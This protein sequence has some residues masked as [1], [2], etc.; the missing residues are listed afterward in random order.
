MLL[1]SLPKSYTNFRCAIESRDTL[2]IPEALRLK[3]FEENDSRKNENREN[4]SNSMLVRGKTN[5]RK[6]KQKMEGSRRD[7]EGQS[8]EKKEI[9][10]YKCHRCRKIGHKA[11]DCTEEIR[12]NN[13]ANAVDQL[14]LCATLNVRSVREENSCDFNYQKR[15]SEKSAN[16][17]TLYVRKSINAEMW[18][19]D[20]GCTHMCNNTNFFANN[21]SEGRNKVSLA[22]HASSQ[23]TGTGSICFNVKQDGRNKKVTLDNA[24]CVPDLRLNLLSVGRI[25]D[26]NMT[27]IFK[28]DEARIMDK[29]QNLVLRANRTDNG[30][31]CIQPIPGESSAN[32]ESKTNKVSPSSSIGTCYRLLGHLNYKDLAQAIEEG[33]VEGIKPEKHSKNDACEICIKAKMTRPPFTRKETERKTDVLEIIHTDICGPMRTESLAKSKYFI[34]F[35]DDATRWCEVRFLRQKSEALEAL[36]P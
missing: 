18:C 24:L 21:F 33:A 22:N 6:S 16:P 8:S 30:L 1:Y 3:I 23:V 11:A 10:K 19:V 32:V 25:C 34:I 29:D 12:R 20:S 31:Y 26:K 14:S 35:V 9:F 27:I 28:R 2:P 4:S 5:E 15:S 36:K 17:K 7:K 13:D